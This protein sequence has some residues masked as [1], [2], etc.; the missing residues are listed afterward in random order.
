[1]KIL[2][3]F[4]AVIVCT[5]FVL[6]QAGCEIDNTSDTTLSGGTPSNNTPAGNNNNNS[7]GTGTGSGNT[8][9]GTDGGSNQNPSGNNGGGGS[10]TNQFTNPGPTLLNADLFKQ[11]NG[12]YQYNNQN[13][14][15]C[16]ELGFFLLTQNPPIT[17]INCGT[18]NFP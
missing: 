1:M 12:T 4:M 14:A 10:S 13:F 5:L 6:S 8:S 18:S 11:G 2:N 15:N 3:G 17:L 9:S 16:D 7:S